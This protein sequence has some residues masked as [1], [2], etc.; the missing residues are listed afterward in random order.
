MSP[1]YK[2]L[3]VAV[4]TGLLLYWTAVFLNLLPWLRP[5]VV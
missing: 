1:T 5:T 4:D 3:L 2:R